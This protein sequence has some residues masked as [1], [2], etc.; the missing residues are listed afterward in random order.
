MG[1]FQTIATFLNAFVTEHPHRC[2]VFIRCAGQIGDA[3]VVGATKAR[4][5]VPV[6]YAKH[7]FIGRRIAN[8]ALGSGGTIQGV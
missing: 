8:G 1:I 2:A 3:F 7:T 6:A 4:S 5:A